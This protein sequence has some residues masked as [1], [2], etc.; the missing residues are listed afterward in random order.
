MNWDLFVIGILLNIY[1]LWFFK[2]RYDIRK[3]GYDKI[4]E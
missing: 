3:S 1:S 4:D 2:I